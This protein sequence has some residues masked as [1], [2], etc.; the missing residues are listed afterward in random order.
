MKKECIICGGTL[1]KLGHPDHASYAWIHKN[2]AECV[3]EMADR[4]QNLEIDRNW[5]SVQVK[6]PP[7][8][9]DTCPLSDIY[10]VK[11]PGKQA[12]EGFCDI[13]T[14]QWFKNDKHGNFLNGVTHWALLPK[15][16]A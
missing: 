11:R 12:I 6:F 2:M 13:E 3:S 5:I 8:L 7:A 14:R 15:N 16:C 9:D 10:L 4:I 1:G